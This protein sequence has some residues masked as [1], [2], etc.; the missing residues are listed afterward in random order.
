MVKPEEVKAFELGYRGEIDGFSLDINGYY[1]IYNDFIGNLTVVAPLY[2]TASNS[3]D[4]AQGA[5]T[6]LTNEEVQST[7]AVIS[8]NYRVF[9]LYTNTD[10]DI[11]SLG[12]G[13]GM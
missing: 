13:F 3:F 2:G 7:H 1:N 5:P 11:T 12:F 10:I 4:F 8:N 6:Y 9:Q